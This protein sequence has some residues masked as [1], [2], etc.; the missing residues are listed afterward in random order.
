MEA[1]DVMTDYFA[2]GSNMDEAEMLTW[3][4][5]HRLIGAAWLDDYRLAFTRRSVRTGTGVADVVSEPGERVWGVLYEIGPQE[6]R[7][8]DRK[9]GNG[10]AYQ[11]QRCRVRLHADG[12]EHDAVTYTVLRKESREVPP[13]REYLDRMI[14]GARRHGLPREYIAVLAQRRTD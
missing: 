12:S 10:R 6:L 14:A 13:S 8:L 11:R 2:Y 1:D 3:C 9:E 7:E 5:G 4:T